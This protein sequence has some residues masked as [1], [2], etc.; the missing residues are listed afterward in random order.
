MATAVK[1]AGGDGEKLTP[2]MV[3]NPTFFDVAINEL[4][5]SATPDTGDQILIPTED[6]TPTILTW[7]GSN[8]G[9]SALEQY[10]RPNGRKGTRVIRKTDHTIGPGRGFWYYRKAT[11]ALSVTFPA[12]S[13]P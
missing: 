10:T 1:I 6:S 7:N 12:P 5:W 13:A 11:G 2:T 9:A 4:A 8:W 3:V